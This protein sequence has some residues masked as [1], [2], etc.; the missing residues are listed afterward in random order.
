MSSRWATLQEPGSSGA[1]TGP[2]GDGAAKQPLGRVGAF[3]SGFGVCT[4]WRDL[5]W[6]FRGEYLLTEEEM[7]LSLPSARLVEGQARSESVRL[8]LHLPILTGRLSCLACPPSRPP[9]HP[10]PA[11]A[12]LSRPLSP[13]AISSGFGA[14]GSDF[15]L[16]P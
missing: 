5:S 1:E 2:W 9:F 10:L 11:P 13:T 14:Q 12:L 7:G 3:F 6:D 16:W 4:G 8:A 15:L